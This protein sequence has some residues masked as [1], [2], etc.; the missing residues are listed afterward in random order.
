LFESPI[1]NGTINYLKINT[2]IPV[3]YKEIFGEKSDQLDMFQEFKESQFGNLE[4]L[5]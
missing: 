5:W 2:D 1:W 4:N 3:N